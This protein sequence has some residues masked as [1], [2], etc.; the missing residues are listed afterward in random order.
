MADRIA[1]EFVENAAIALAIDPASALKAGKEHATAKQGNDPAT[2]ARP[3]VQLDEATNLLGLGPG[4][5][6]ST[7]TALSAA[8]PSAAVVIAPLEGLDISEMLA[9]PCVPVCDIVETLLSAGSQSSLGD[10][11]DEPL[12]E[13][14]GLLV[15]GALASEEALELL[16]G[17]LASSHEA[18]Q[19]ADLLIGATLDGSDWHVSALLAAVCAPAKELQMPN[20][21]RLLAEL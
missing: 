8:V 13:L 14:V 12:R 15:G 2:K 20:N 17:H 5:T 10:K 21:L 9:A 11:G 19:A 16:D 7:V 1:N 4:S 3:A 6:A 18:Q